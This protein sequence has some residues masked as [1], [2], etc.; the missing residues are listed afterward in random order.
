MRVICAVCIGAALRIIWGNDLSP[1][2]RISSIIHNEITEHLSCH[3]PDIDPF[4]KSILA[5]YTKTEAIACNDGRYFTKQNGSI[6][7]IDE[8]MKPAALDYC[9]YNP[10]I[11][12]NDNSDYQYQFV[13]VKFK[14]RKDVKVEHEFIRVK[15]FDKSKREIYRN[16]HATTHCI[17]EIK[18]SDI[19]HAFS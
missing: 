11:R 8:K 13:D 19:Q 10:I 15:C 14:F 16:F 9:E 6:V 4:D 17:R 5:F 18:R 1:K 7:S 2:S 3:I 12:P